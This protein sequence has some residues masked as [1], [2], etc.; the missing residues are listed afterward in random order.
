MIAAIVNI[1]NYTNNPFFGFLIY[2]VT[3]CVAY[4]TMYD[5]E[6]P[7]GLV[8]FYV[9]LT[10]LTIVFTAMYATQFYQLVERCR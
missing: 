9:F 6:G 7:K 3:A 1:L 8:R 5:E 2:V 10:Y 4:I